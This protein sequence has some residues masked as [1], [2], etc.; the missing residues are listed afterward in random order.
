MIIAK[1]LNQPMVIIALVG[2]AAFI[3]HL[4]P[5]FLKFKGGK[6][7]ATA[8]G[9]YIGLN[10][11][12]GLIIVLSWIICSLIFNISSLSALVATSM[13]PFLFYFITQSLEASL[14]LALI[15]LLVFWRHRENIKKIINGNESKIIKK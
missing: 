13:A 8:L 6:G 2:F 10:P 1:L 12:F 5:V 3:G 4:Y 9:V 11:I 7:V 14:I 15:T